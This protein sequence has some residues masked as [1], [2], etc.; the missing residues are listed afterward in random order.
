M[1]PPAAE[2]K[3]TWMADVKVA[4]IGGSGLGETLGREVKG[5]LREMDTPFGKPSGPILE[6]EWEGVPIAFL[7]RH[8]PGHT[9][10]PSAVPFRANLF[11][12]KALGVT[13]AIASGAV[14]SLR[15]DYAPKHLVIPDQVIDKTFRRAGT[16]FDSGM[17]VHV[18]LADPFCGRMRQL[19]L[20]AGREAGG[21]VHPGGTYVCMEGPQFSTV[22]ESHMHQKWGGDLIG[23]TCMPEAKLAREAEIAYG[24]V[25][26]VTDYDCWRSHD[27][28]V[29]KRELLGEIIGNLKEAS[30]NATELIRAA[31]RRI[32]E[33]GPIDS[34]AHQALELA[35]WSD[36][37]QVDRKVVERL[38]PL[39]SKYFD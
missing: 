29:S 18:E 31:L 20:D 4:I 22:A 23:M 14:G 1:S 27:P 6:G 37:S 9:L 36:K 16:F 19:L 32:A 7:A 25:A 26:L 15:E 38:G 33:S 17:V 3:G 2:W 35:I 24:L 12:L 21:T 28:S 39:V 11:A 34:D 30:A 10:N 8:G 5:T 13:H